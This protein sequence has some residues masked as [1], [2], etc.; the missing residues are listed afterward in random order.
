MMNKGKIGKRQGP[1]GTT[2]EEKR[3]TGAGS[4]LDLYNQRVDSSWRQES[5]DHECSGE[6]HE[7]WQCQGEH[8]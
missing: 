7:E 8:G 1:E 5:G 2:K 3:S 6:W 4:R